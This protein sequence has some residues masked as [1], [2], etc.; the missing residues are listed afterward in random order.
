MPFLPVNIR[1]SGLRV[2]YGGQRGN[3]IGG[4]FKPVLTRVAIPVA[5]CVVVLLAESIKSNWQESDELCSKESRE[6]G[7]E[8]KTQRNKQRPSKEAVVSPRAENYPNEMSLPLPK[9]YKRERVLFVP[10]K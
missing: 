2:Y 3:R 5:K 4:F 7:T 10:V 9:R 8:K 6:L 1:A